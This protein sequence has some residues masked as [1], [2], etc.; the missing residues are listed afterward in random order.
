M[1]DKFFQELFTMSDSSI[2]ANIITLA[3]RQKDINTHW[4]NA[5]GSARYYSDEEPKNAVLGI[6]LGGTK[7]AWAVYPVV[8]GKILETPIKEGQV[9]TKRGLVALAGTYTEV[10]KDSMQQAAAEGFVLTSVGLG[11]PGRFVNKTYYDNTFEDAKNQA[12]DNI[13]RTLAHQL[14]PT[15]IPGI[16]I[17][18]TVKGETRSTTYVKEQTTVPFKT[19]LKV[20][21]SVGS[22]ANLESYPGEF[23]GVAIESILQRLTPLGLQLSMKND[24]AVQ[25]QGLVGSMN[26]DEAARVKGKKIVYIGPG[27][28]LGGAVMNAKGELVTD[29]H[30]QYMNLE[31]LPND[32]SVFDIIH[33]KHEDEYRSYN[34]PKRTVL[35]ENL[36]SGTGVKDILTA[37]Y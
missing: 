33:K 10:L 7:M 5:L 3:E 4:K 11:S 8:D 34:L 23:D 1:S 17:P 19:G 2:K 26:G 29:G 16:G 18:Y 25:L 27:T 21:G 36:M 14:G 15:H 20:I 37:T 35:P 28:G 30:H 24:A 6:D 32:E 13:Q 22:A 31:Q 9:A 12:P